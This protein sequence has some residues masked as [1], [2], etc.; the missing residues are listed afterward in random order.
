MKAVLIS[1]RPEWCEKICHKIGTDKDGKPMWR[2]GYK[3]NIKEN[4]NA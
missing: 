2:N 3:W 4:N 1:T